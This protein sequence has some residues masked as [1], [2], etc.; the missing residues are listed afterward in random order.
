MRE[1][2]KLAPSSAVIYYLICA[3][4]VRI[5]ISWGAG[6]MTGSSFTLTANETLLL[7]ALQQIATIVICFFA[8]RYHGLLGSDPR[9]FGTLPAEYDG[10][11]SDRG[12]RGRFA[13]RGGRAGES[14]GALEAV[15]AVLVVFLTMDVTSEVPGWISRFIPGARAASSSA[16]QSMIEGGNI[17]LV[18]A[19]FVI[20]APLAEEMLIRGL[21]YNGLKTRLGWAPAAIFASMLWAAMHTTWEQA[22]AA[23]IMGLMMCFL[24]E[25]YDSLWLTIAIHAVNNFISLYGLSEIFNKGYNIRVT[26]FITLAELVGAIYFCYRIYGF[27][28]GTKG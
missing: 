14:V 12:A 11:R 26:M 4:T 28:R 27:R 19:L 1:H 25:M 7:N 17:A 9:S 21:L 3:F 16:I 8:F 13:G 2:H 10:A 22:L 6:I 20:L 23:A 18:F 5:V 15:M 24:Y